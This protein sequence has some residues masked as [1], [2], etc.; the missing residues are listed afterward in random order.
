MACLG[1]TAT[2]ADGGLISSLIEVLLGKDSSHA[3]RRP[4]YICF[5]FTQLYYIC[6]VCPGANSKEIR[7]HAGAV[8]WA[9]T[10]G[11]AGLELGRIQP[12][13]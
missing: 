5:F 8:A 6:V 12:T 9:K 3:S 2:T 11:P 10:T 1:A 4:Y 7:M 13:F